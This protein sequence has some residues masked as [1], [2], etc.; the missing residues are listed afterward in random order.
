MAKKRYPFKSPSSCVQGTIVHMSVAD[1]QIRFRR[2]NKSHVGRF[3]TNFSIARPYVSF[4][5]RVI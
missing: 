4:V 5:W 2:M 3:P 1:E